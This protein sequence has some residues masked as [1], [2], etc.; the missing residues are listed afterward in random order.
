M[1]M[2]RPCL[3]ENAWDMLQCH[4][5]QHEHMKKQMKADKLS[6]KKGKRIKPERIPQLAYLQ[7]AIESKDLVGKEKIRVS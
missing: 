2:T 6:L 3:K 1:L 7:G 5:M 4:N